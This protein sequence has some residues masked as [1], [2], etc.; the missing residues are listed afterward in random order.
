MN[1]FMDFLIGSPCVWQELHAALQ[2]KTIVKRQVESSSTNRYV[3]ND[4]RS[5]IM[6]LDLANKPSRGRPKSEIC[7]H[8][9]T[10]SVN[11]C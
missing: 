8:P 7:A 1:L 5:V 3:I 6:M 4:T 9:S 2:E 10:L 11:Q